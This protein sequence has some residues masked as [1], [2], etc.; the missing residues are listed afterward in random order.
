MR[1]LG[2]ILLAA[3][4][5]ST[6]LTPGD[7]D[8]IGGERMIDAA[9]DA[10]PDAFDPKCYGS[11]AFY[12]CLATMPMGNTTLDGQTILTTPCN[13]NTEFVAMLGGVQVCVIAADRITLNAGQNAGIVGNK[14]LVLIATTAMTINGTLD[15]SSVRGNTGPNANPTVCN[16]AGTTGAT[17]TAGGGGGA[18]GSFGSV[19]GRGGNGGGGGGGTAAAIVTQPVT[20]LRGGCAGG[21]GATGVAG[22]PTAGGPGGGAVY[23]VSRGT[24]TIG[25]IV[26]ASGGGGE[27]ADDNKIGGGGGGAGGMIV[28]DAGTLT[29][30]AGARILANGGGGAAGAGNSGAADDGRE[31]IPATPLVPALG[32]TNTGS[33]ATPGGPGAA[34]AT[35]AMPGMNSANGGSGGGG[36][37]GVVRVLRG[38][39]IPVAQVSPPPS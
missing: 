3:C 24:L 20:V 12:L 38:G 7:G 8:N 34:G 6:A 27:G 15:A 17:N 26:N 32:G 14:P 16:N 18:G 35:A 28:I 19:G 11:G 33:G 9:P 25:G 10:P 39:T 30:N 5:F 21:G 2:L 1:W 29:I 31:P 22:T 23:L 4:K 36:G 13:N 37:V